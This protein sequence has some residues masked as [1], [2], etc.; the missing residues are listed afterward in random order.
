MADNYN[1][2]PNCLFDSH[3]HL[4]L[5]LRKLPVKRYSD[6]SI[7]HTVHWDGQGTELHHMGGLITN[8]CYPNRWPTER[9]LSTRPSKVHISVGVHP[10]QA[11]LLTPLNVEK[12]ER[13]VR[14]GNVVAMGECGLDYSRSGWKNWRMQE[15]TFLT[16]LE[17]AMKYDLPVIVHA[18]EAEDEL[19]K[20][21]AKAGVPR[22]WPIHRHCFTENWVSADRW[23]TTYPA[24]KIGLT[25]LVTYP[26][27][28]SVRDVALHIPLTRLLLETDAPY[29]PP[30]NRVLMSRSF[31]SSYSL[32]SHV[33]QVAS[34]VAM[35]KQCDIGAVLNSNLKNVADIYRI[36]TNYY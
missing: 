2:W 36:Q 33:L 16:Q 25:A 26:H 32:P 4:D 18:R 29:F 31:Q 7:A 24:S 15:T 34:E 19:Y 14:G 3:C 23:L 12:L 6:S 22:N 27:A 28:T 1:L 10:K 13:L 35:I 8:M 11:N 5:A 30:K 17:M 21:L 9:V 20:L